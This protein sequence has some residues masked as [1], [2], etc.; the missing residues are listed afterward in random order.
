MDIVKNT[1]LALAFLLELCMLAALCY[2]GF[3]A[4]QGTLQKLVLGLGT[5][6]VVAVVWGLFAAPRATRRLAG[7]GLFALKALLFCLAAVALWI[8]GLPA[9]AIVFIVVVVLNGLLLYA[10]RQ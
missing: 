5:P 8:A 10:W 3:V 1:N 7:F 2:W 4:G 6:L 9:L